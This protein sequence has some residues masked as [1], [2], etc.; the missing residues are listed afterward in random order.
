MKKDAAMALACLALCLAAPFVGEPLSGENAA[1]ILW[2]LRL[3]RVLMGLIAGGALSLV[4][5]TYQTIFAN[6]LASE[7]TVGTLAGATLGAVIALVFGLGSGIAGVPT[8]ALFAFCGALAVTL[9]LTAIASSGRASLHSVLLAG[10]AISLM[11]SALSTGLQ[12][13]A[14]LNSMFTAARWS[15]GHLQQ[16]GYGGIG[17]VL[18]FVLPACALLLWNTRALETLAGGE[19]RAHSQ[20]VDVATLRA[21]CLGAGALAVAACVA[22]CGPI[23]F[24]GLIVP[25]L[26]RLLVGASRRRLLP[27][28]LVMGGT[29]LV[30]CDALARAAWPGRELPVGVVTAALGAPALVWLI[31]RRSP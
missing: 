10:I 22:V 25:H 1:F 24:V 5:G 26:A 18:A 17:M 2:Q 20:G 19:D 28:S 4:G 7:S 16:M 12:Y 13:T 31:A 29:F 8:V 21:T 30:A 3:P 14:D 27:W 9:L 15:L 11:A 6:P 23:A